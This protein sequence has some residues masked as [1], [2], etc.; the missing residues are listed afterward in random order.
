MI[1]PGIPIS[2]HDRC[3]AGIL[4]KAVAI[5]TDA[6]VL[7]TKPSNCCKIH[8]HRDMAIAYQL[9]CLVKCPSTAPHEERAAPLWA[10]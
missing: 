3:K 2:S 7:Y 10:N 9:S 1:F 4:R 5:L 8:S 6:S